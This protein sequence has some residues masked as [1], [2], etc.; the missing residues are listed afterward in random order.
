MLH[1]VETPINGLKLKYILK[2]INKFLSYNSMK[3]T[4]DFILLN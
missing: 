1:N 2:Q 3:A 4:T